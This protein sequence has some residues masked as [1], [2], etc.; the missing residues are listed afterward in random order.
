M[1]SLA[2]RNGGTVIF[3]FM[4]ARL[5]GSSALVALSVLPIVK[6]LA[7][8]HPSGHTTSTL[9]SWSLLAANVSQ[10]RYSSGDGAHTRIDIRTHPSYNC[11]LR[12]MSF[13][14]KIVDSS[15]DLSHTIRIRCLHL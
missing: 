15:P 13:V 10:S 2:H 7:G 12:H 4:M 6:T 11:T 14:E 3:G 8:A 9:V 1:V 5:L